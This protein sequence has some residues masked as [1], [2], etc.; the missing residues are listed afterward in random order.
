[1]TTLMGR[2]ANLERLARNRPTANGRRTLEAIRQ[3]RASL[4]RLAGMTP[5][6]WQESQLRS[7]SSRMML[8]ASR[9]AGKSETAA[10]IALAEALVVPKATVLV[11]SPSLRQSGE[12]FKKV[13][14]QYAA[15]GRPIRAVAETKTE[16]ALVNGSRILSLPGT[17]ATIR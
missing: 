1:M 4:F 14:A 3:D 10:G 13:T 7:L 2:L 15:L 12:L 6:P 8:L 16:L 11:L 17:E 5:D 9:Q